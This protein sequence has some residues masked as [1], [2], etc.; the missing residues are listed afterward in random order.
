MSNSSTRL[1]PRLRTAGATAFEQR[2]LQSAA[3]EQPSRELSERMAA[4]IGISAP[5]LL[6]APRPATSAAKAGAVGARAVLPWLSGGLLVLAIGGAALG[7]LR[8][9]RGAPPARV[10]PTLVSAA[11]APAA[12]IAPAPSAV[13]VAPS[14]QA[15]S[16]SRPNLRNNASS[17]AADL[18]AQITLIDAA[19]V[20]VSA[21]AGERAL[22]ILREYET[23]YGAGSFRPEVRALKIE[24]LIAVGRDSEARALASR[25]VAD[26][27][28]SSLAQRVARITGL[29]QA[30]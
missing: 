4:A 5:V 6:A 17:S 27:R 29:T 15:P 11:A 24:A 2:L 28:G 10:A 14:E 20:A 22:G 26:Y 16:A 8:R 1:P 18:R 19:R 3:S 25:F 30:H 12:P 9:T 23:K 13:V 7:L 21:G